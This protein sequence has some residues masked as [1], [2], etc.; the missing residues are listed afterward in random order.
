VAFIKV[1]NKT[2]FIAEISSN[3]NCN[4]KRC[5]KLIDE[6]KK[7]GFDA[8]KFQLFKLKEL[9][10]ESTLTKNKFLNNRKKWELPVKYIPKIKQH[11]LKKKIDF[12]CTPFYLEAVDEL[13][14]YV[15]FFKIASYEL[16]WDDLFDKCISTNKKII[17]STGMANKKEIL[18]RLDF[19]RKKNFYNFDILHCISSYPAKIKDLNLKTIPFIRD[20]LKKYRMSKNIRVGWSDHSVNEAV[21]YKSIFQYNSQVIEM[22]IDLEGKG[23]EYHYNHCWLPEKAQKIIKNIRDFKNSNEFFGKKISLIEK[24]ERNWRT[25]NTDGLRPLLKIRK[26]F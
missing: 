26:F 18:S 3:H 20:L 7:A 12:G 11:C 19:L 10:T 6:A 21:I 15:D 24:K 4:L 1:M 17:F 9:F 8:V 2:Y 23:N 16:L 14:E 25:E 13:K 5:Y 22:H